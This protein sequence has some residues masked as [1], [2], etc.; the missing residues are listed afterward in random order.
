VKPENQAARERMVAKSPPD[1]VARDLPT[2]PKTEYKGATDRPTGANRPAS[3]SR[4]SG[5]NR[6]PGA[7][8]SPQQPPA[9]SADRGRDRSAAAHPSADRP[10]AAQDRSAGSSRERPAISPAPPTAPQAA[11]PQHADRTAFG[12]GDGA[13][14]SGRSEKQASER[15]RSSMGSGGSNKP[16]KPHR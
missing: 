9:G 7:R 8:E 15:G 3:A 6:P 14:A 16:R 5:A 2:R 4:S 12:S 1:G 13:H 10:A 11:A